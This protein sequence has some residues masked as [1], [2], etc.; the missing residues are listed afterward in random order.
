[1][2]IRTAMCAAALLLCQ[3][4]GAFAQDKTPATRT[5]QDLAARLEATIAPYFQPDAPGATVIVVKDG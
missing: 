2:F 1:M 4:Q 5:A 3:P